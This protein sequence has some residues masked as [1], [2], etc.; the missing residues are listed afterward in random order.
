MIRVTR[1]NA[2][3]LAINAEMIVFVEETPDTVITLSTH[4]KVLV[5][6]PADEIIRRVIEYGRKV[7]GAIEGSPP[8]GGL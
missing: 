6:E 4:D 3:P 2:K 5:K 1:L 8:S 7:R